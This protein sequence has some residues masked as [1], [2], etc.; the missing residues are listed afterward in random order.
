MNMYLLVWHEHGAKAIGTA[1]RALHISLRHKNR[2]LEFHVVYQYP[3][4]RPLERS[5][6]F[7]DLT[8]FADARPS[9]HLHLWG[10]DWNSH[11]GT[12]HRHPQVG[13]HLLRHPTSAHT[14]QMMDSLFEIISRCTDWLN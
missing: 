11:F 2:D 6:L 10:G 8:D 14:Q 3:G 7:R 13:R 1:G 4:T 5:Q 12:D 9:G